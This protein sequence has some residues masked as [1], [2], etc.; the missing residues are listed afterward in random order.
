MDDKTKDLI[1]RKLDE[2]MGTLSTIGPEF[3]FENLET[4]DAGQI[5]AFWDMKFSRCENADYTAPETQA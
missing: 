1:Q 4:D 5:I 2:L 3:R